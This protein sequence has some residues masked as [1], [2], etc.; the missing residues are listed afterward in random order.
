[1]GGWIEGRGE[2]NEF[3]GKSLKPN[4]VEEYAASC[5]LKLLQSWKQSLNNFS[6]I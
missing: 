6:F 5:S 2:E 4:V 3:G 1:M